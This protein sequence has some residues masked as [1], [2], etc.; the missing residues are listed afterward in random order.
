MCMSGVI[1]YEKENWHLME[2]GN[3]FLHWSETI[4]ALAVTNSFKLMK[5]KE[6]DVPK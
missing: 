5:H 4:G 6:P 3:N 2:D 1:E